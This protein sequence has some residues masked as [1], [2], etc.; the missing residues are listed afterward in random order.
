VA[1][2]GVAHEAQNQRQGGR[3]QV[4][5]Q[6]NNGGSPLETASNRLHGSRTMKIKTNVKAGKTSD[7]SFVHKVDKAS[8]VL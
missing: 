2:E 5:A 7:I 1:A 4:P 8:P 3:E 6:R